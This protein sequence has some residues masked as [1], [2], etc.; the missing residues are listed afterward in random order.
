MKTHYI[1]LGSIP[2]KYVWIGGLRWSGMKTH[3]IPLGS[4]VWTDIYNR[5]EGLMRK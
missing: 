2:L 1:L 4:I 5:M 3:Y